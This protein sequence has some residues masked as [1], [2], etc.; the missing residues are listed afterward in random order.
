MYKHSKCYLLRLSSLCPALT[1]R[2]SRG[3]EAGGLEAA[4]LSNISR[5]AWTACTG[6]QLNI[7]TVLLYICKIIARST[8]KR[9]KLD[10]IE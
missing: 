1:V 9:N 7:L 2:T 6:T 8:L 4:E 10:S 3:Q 5:L